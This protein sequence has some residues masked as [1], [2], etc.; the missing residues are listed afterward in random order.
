MERSKVEG[1]RAE[2][3]NDFALPSLFLLRAKVYKSAQFC[4]KPDFDHLRSVISRDKPRIEHL[5]CR[6]SSQ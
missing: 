1:K 2:N 4:F 3:P 6:G 5:S